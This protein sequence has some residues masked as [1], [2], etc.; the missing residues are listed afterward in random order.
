MVTIATN[1]KLWRASRMLSQDEL[2]QR[3]G[4]TGDTISRMES[5]QHKPQQKTLG[6]LAKAYGVAPQ[7]LLS[8]PPVVRSDDPHAQSAASS[9]GD[10][11]QQDSDRGANESVHT[12]STVASHGES[13]K[14]PASTGGASR[15]ESA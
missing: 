8:P 15:R 10:D 9:P 5:G 4:I 2:A 11:K 7:D 3:A 6:K 12:Q 13:D 1:L 14:P